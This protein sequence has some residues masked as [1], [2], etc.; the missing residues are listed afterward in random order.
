MIGRL[1]LIVA[2]LT[3]LAPSLFARSVPVTG[4]SAEGGTVLC[5]AVDPVSPEVIYAGTW[6]GLYRSTDAGLNWS[7]IK[8]PFADPV[9]SLTW[10]S[11]Q[12]RL[13]AGGS[14]RVFVADS[15][16]SS[17]GT[18]SI[19]TDGAPPVTAILVDSTISQALFAGTSGRGLF[20]SN[21]GGLNWTAIMPGMADI[22]RPGILNV[23]DIARESSS[24][25]VFVATWDGLFRVGQGGLL[26]VDYSRTSALVVRPQDSVL[27]A[28]VGWDIRYRDPVFSV[29]GTTIGWKTLNAIGNAPYLIDLCFDPNDPSILWAGATSGLYRGRFEVDPATNEQG[30]AWTMI[31]EIEDRIGSVA[32]SAAKSGTVFAA[33]LSGVWKSADAGKSWLVSNAGIRSSRFLDVVGVS[34]DPGTILGV[35]LDPGP[36]GGWVRVLRSSDF[37]ATWQLSFEDRDYSPP[38]PGKPSLAIDPRPPGPGTLYL[39]G[40]R[41]S[42]DL[43]QT[44]TA[45]I[46][47]TGGTAGSFYVDP[48]NPENQAVYAYYVFKPQFPPVFY[49]FTRVTTD[50]WQTYRELWGGGGPLLRFDPHSAGSLYFFRGDPTGIHR[51]DYGSNIDSL[52]IPLT[53]AE[54][55]EPDRFVPGRLYFI[56]DR[57]L[58]LHPGANGQAERSA[59]PDDWGVFVVRSHP[60]EP[61]LI[62]A[63]VTEGLV[64]SRDHGAT[65]QNL[66]RG[67]SVGEVLGISFDPADPSIVYLAA[68]RGAFRLSLKNAYRQQERRSTQRRREE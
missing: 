21:D 65:W 58:Y 19:P 5:V 63:G 66:V 37:G 27:Y 4:G 32:C 67:Q 14:G 18:L 50:G 6:A 24:G 20:S 56:F 64:A 26:R 29:Y 42:M 36:V 46:P 43:G 25:T 12:S 51:W 48:T 9:F 60:S 39:D 8:L 57:R 62:L 33:G 7:L 13:F 55:L 28:A 41:A 31:G 22:E 59:L 30:I 38:Y 17:W 47:F 23:N 52:I 3:Y 15:S 53:R 68:S 54:D 40:R 16:G 10:D 44:W 49:T 35:T 1:V 34:G 2:V 45:D 61:G 11:G